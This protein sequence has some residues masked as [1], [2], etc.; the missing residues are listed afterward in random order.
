MSIPGRNPGD[1]IAERVR[2]PARSIT[3][4]PF[5][6]DTS[7]LSPSSSCA[8]CATD[9]GSRRPRL[10]PHFAIRVVIDDSVSTLNIP[11]VGP[12]IK[13]PGLFG[14]LVHLIAS[15]GTRRYVTARQTHSSGP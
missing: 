9:F 1:E 6:T 12:A 10:L 2:R 13:A 14:D 7:T 3:I 11:S 8:S 5:L 15:A 4:A